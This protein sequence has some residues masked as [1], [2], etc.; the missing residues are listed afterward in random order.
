MAAVVVVEMLVVVMMMI[1]MVVVMVLMV[2][3]A[4]N[5]FYSFKRHFYTDFS[6]E[7]NGHSKR[8]TYNINTQEHYEYRHL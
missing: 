8:V 3:T 1:M 2:M 7:E 4:A 6:D 5:Y